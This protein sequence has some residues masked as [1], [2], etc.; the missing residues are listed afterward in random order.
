MTERQRDSELERLPEWSRRY[1]LALLTKRPMDVAKEFG[2]NSALVYEARH[3]ANR[4][5]GHDSPLM[6]SMPNWQQC[7]GRPRKYTG[8]GNPELASLPNGPFVE[9]LTTPGPDGHVHVARFDDNGNGRTND[10]GGHIH[11]I[12]ECDVASMSGHGHELTDQRA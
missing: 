11:R 7:G 6:E 10:A 5:L 8:S 2:V 4:R 9:L 3:L 12:V 1:V